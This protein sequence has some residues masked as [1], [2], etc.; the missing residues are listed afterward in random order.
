[1]VDGER[2][3]LGGSVNKILLVMEPQIARFEQ[4]N[5]LNKGPLW[6]VIVVLGGHKPS[7]QNPEARLVT[8]LKCLK[9]QQQV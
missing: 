3:G 1:M 8:L 7:S 9:P 6:R 4:H 2:R 5:G